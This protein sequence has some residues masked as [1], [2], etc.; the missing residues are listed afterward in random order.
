MLDYP[1]DCLEVE[2]PNGTCW[3]EQAWIWNLS[4]LNC[5]AHNNLCMCMKP[6]M[7]RWW[8]VQENRLQQ[9]KLPEPALCIGG[10]LL[11]ELVGR[12]QDQGEFYYIGFVSQI[13]SCLLS[14][15]PTELMLFG[16]YCRQLK[17]NRE[18]GLFPFHLSTLQFDTCPLME[19]V[20]DRV[21][22]ALL[23]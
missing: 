14:H 20:L 3:I 8:I 23:I 16:H 17:W 18:V 15:A 21:L 11:V 19:W 12:V 9:F 22:L 6:K 10:V 1:R 7:C 13:F 5:I 2:L 4:I